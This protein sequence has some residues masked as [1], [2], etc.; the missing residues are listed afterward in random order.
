MSFTLFVVH[1]AQNPNTVCT[2]E[3]SGA[4]LSET[5]MCQSCV[6]EEN[7]DLNYC[8]VRMRMSV[9][10]QLYYT[11]VK[12]LPHSGV[13]LICRFLTFGYLFWGIFIISFIL[14]FLTGSRSIAM[15]C[16]QANARHTIR[17]HHHTS[18]RPANGLH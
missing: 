17:H 6:K 16:F 12:T 11:I 4:G 1:T 9:K 2:A 8:H 13:T 10:L 3:T 7:F 5:T 14:I 15:T 18:F